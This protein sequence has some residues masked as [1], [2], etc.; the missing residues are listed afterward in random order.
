MTDRIGP[1][2]LRHKTARQLAASWCME[3]PEGW[4]VSFKAPTR[5]LEQNAKL[6]AM[7][8][9]LSKQVPWCGQTL[10]VEQWK[11]FATAKLKKDKIIFDCN[12]LG[13]PD[14]Q[15]GLVVL[16]AST[17]DKSVKEISEI[18]EW[19]YWMGARHGVAWSEYAE[20]THRASW[21]LRRSV[22]ALDPREP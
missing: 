1:F 6:H 7:A 19:F 16:G 21:A 12:D 2:F 22:R 8:G 3:A 13:Q 5:S 11:R 4:C 18:I 10:S 9:D 15:A 14:P 17:R 20:Y